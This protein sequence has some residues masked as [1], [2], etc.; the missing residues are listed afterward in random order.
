MYCIQNMRG[1]ALSLL[2]CIIYIHCYNFAETG[3]VISAIYYFIH[4]CSTFYRTE[5]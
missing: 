1:Y 3:K 4:I 5:S 2:H